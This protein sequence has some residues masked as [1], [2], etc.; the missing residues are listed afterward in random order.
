MQNGPSREDQTKKAKTSGPR[1]RARRSGGEGPIL[2]NRSE[3]NELRGGLIQGVSIPSAPR[4]LGFV[5]WADPSGSSRGGRSKGSR[6]KGA[7]PSGPIQGAGRKYSIRVGWAEWAD[8]SG[9]I[10]V[11]RSK[12]PSG[13]NQSDVADPRRPSGRTRS[14]WAEPSGCRSKVGEA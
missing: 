14:E 7:A 5:K 11:G 9:P 10:R 13:S 3:R 2:V 4:R 12:E 8:P 1:G 6:V